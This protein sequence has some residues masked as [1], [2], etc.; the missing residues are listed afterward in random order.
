M[1]KLGLL[2]VCVCACVCSGI[3]TVTVVHNNCKE[4]YFQI[5]LNILPKVH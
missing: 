1:S 4:M 3:A 2:L 5:I